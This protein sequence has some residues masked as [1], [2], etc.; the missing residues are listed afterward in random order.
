MPTPVSARIERI[1]D[2][3]VFV[4]LPDGQTLHLPETAL[5]GTPGVGSDVRILALSQ[6]SD[7]SADQALA[8]SLLNELLGTN[9]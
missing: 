4:T 5:Y 7:I 9:S 6:P 2:G 8:H 3:T 1:Q